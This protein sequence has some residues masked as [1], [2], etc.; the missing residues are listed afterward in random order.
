MT[1]ASSVL[2]QSIRAVEKKEF[3]IENKLLQLFG[4]FR[5]IPTELFNT[6]LCSQFVDQIRRHDNK[7]MTKVCA[8]MVPRLLTPEQKENRKRICTDILEQIQVDSHFLDKVITCDET[9]IF[10]YDPETKRQS[11]HWKTPSSPKMKKTRQSKS[12]FKAMLIDF[13][14]IKGVIFEH[15]TR[16]HNSESTLL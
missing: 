1:K 15:G 11:M 9:W 13:F 2:R 6:I 8:K 12:K 10:T 16:R 3:N 14:Y 5:G 4:K 7:Y